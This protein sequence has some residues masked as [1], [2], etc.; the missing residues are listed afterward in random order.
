MMLDSLRY[1]F[2]RRRSAPLRRGL[3]IAA[4]VMCACSTCGDAGSSAS[5]TGELGNGTFHYTC[6]GTSDPVCETGLLG[7]QFPDCIAVGGSFELDYTLRDV[8]ELDDDELAPFLFI[9]SAND[10]FFSGGDVFTAHRPGRSAFV[11]RDNDVVVDI[12][13]LDIVAADAIDIVALD[14]ADPVE[15]VELDVGDRAFF[16]VFPRSTQC[17]QLGGSIT[18][19]ANSSDDVV[20]SVGVVDALEIAAHSPGNATVTVELGELSQSITVKVGGAPQR[21]K[22]D[23]PPTGDDSSGGSSSDDGTS[24]AGS[25]DG[26]G[27]DDGSTSGSTGG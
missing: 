23:M 22:P 4:L 8:S 17:A 13:H 26:S 12:L 5:T 19:E 16:R 27:S 1:R 21:N 11:A 9:E 25:S 2:E 18:V 15:V 7:Q 10:S 14:P 24:D 20:A 6:T 3:S